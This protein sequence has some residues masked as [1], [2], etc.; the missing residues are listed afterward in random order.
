MD[1][2]PG[3]ILR[4]AD[5]GDIPAL[6]SLHR[7]MFTEIW[8]Q[9]GVPTDLS[10]MERL[11]EAYAE[12]LEKQFADGSCRGW[13]ICR[14]DRIVS[15]GAVSTCRYVPVPHDPSSTVAFLH[16]VYT[17]EAFR[18]RGLAR[19]ITQEAIDYC[20]KSGIKRLYLFSS[21]AGRPVYEVS[22]FVPVDTMMVQLLS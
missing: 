22:G 21:D 8:E 10:A 19:R 13:V 11:E 2:A 17:D 3:T 14:D 12:K 16:S 9:R 18:G 7:R 20:R 4:V 6:S 5:T 1:F 15:C